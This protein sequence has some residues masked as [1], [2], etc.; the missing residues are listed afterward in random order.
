MEWLD[1]SLAKRFMTADAT[2]LV[3]EALA[4]IDGHLIRCCRL[5]VR[6]GGR[7][8]EQV[9]D[10]IEGRLLPLGVVIQQRRHHA[11]RMGRG[12]IEDQLVQVIRIDPL[13]HTVEARCLPREDPAGR[14]I[15]GRVTRRATQF[16]QQQQSARDRW[17]G[18][19]AVLG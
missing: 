13:S 9:L 11:T 15:R 3:V 2:D 6:C 16:T 7:S 19:I 4:F 8:R 14:T 10:Q 18:S 5:P 17:R 12:G 1:R